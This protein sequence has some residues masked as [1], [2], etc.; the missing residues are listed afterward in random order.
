MNPSL[1]PPANITWTDLFICTHGST[2]VASGSYWKGNIVRTAKGEAN[3]Q[4]MFK[5]QTPPKEQT[6]RGEG[7]KIPESQREESGIT[8]Q[9]MLLPTMWACLF[10]LWPT[11]ASTQAEHRLPRKWVG[12]HWPWPMF[13]I[14]R[15]KSHDA[16]SD[17]SSASCWAPGSRSNTSQ[18]VSAE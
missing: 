3:K 17:W 9:K 15:R 10:S 4:G 11:E 1:H 7:G 18:D 13:Y 6:E 8:N 2:S 5:T 14:P 12:S 16:C